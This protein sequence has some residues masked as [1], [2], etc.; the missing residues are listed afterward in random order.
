MVDKIQDIC[1]LYLNAS[2]R[3]RVWCVDEKSQIQGLGANGRRGYVGWLRSHSKSGRPTLLM[4]RS[5][6]T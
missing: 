1:G 4:N 2:E 6:L 3:P 5:P